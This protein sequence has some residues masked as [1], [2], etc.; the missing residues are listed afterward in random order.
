M[1]GIT[2]KKIMSR[3]TKPDKN[4]LNGFIVDLVL[5]SLFVYGQALSVELFNV[6]FS[7]LAQ[8]RL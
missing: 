2:C 5:N 6:L 4:P 3:R 8:K 1:H 7:L